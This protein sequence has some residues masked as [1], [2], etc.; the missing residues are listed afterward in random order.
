MHTI[1]ITTNLMPYFQHFSHAV[2]HIGYG[3]GRIL[4]CECDRTFG[5]RPPLTKWEKTREALI[6]STCRFRRNHQASIAKKFFT[7]KVFK[8]SA[9]HEHW[10]KD[11]AISEKMQKRTAKRTLNTKTWH[12]RLRPTNEDDSS[13]DNADSD[14]LEGV[15]SRLT[16]CFCCGQ[17]E[18]LDG[19]PQS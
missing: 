16:P 13:G 19:G 18:G 6:G 11:L 17:N 14:E 12:F 7:L 9:W 15:F 10:H 3:C 8:P 1:Y 2:G 4:R 5:F